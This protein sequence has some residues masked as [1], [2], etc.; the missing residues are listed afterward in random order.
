MFPV[1][2]YPDIPLWPVIK[3]WSL[4]IS[5]R[6]NGVR[7]TSE[8]RVP[9]LSL[10]LDLIRLNPDLFVIIEFTPT[11]LIGFIAGKLLRKRILL[12][13]ETDPA[14]RG[15]SSGAVRLALK[16]LIARRVDLVMTNNEPGRAYVCRALGVRAKRIFV[17][18]YLTSAPP[19]AA[20]ESEVACKT[21]DVVSEQIR[22]LYLNSVTERKG[23]I[24]LIQACKCLTDAEL[25]Q[26]IFDVV[27]DGP[28]LN[29]AKELVSQYGMG[30]FF[31]FHGSAAHD[32]I[33][34]YYRLADIFVS[35][36][37]ADYRSLTAFEALSCGKPLLLSRWDSASS[38]VVRNGSN[39]WII[40]PCSPEELAERLVWFAK[41]RSRIPEFAAESKE[42]AQLFSF[43]RIAKNLEVATHLALGSKLEI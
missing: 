36:T 20:V 1:S 7:Y 3:F 23:L 32:Q 6:I 26:F 22:V 38:E 37:L 29:R 40:D 31:K 28:L 24:E 25:G 33:W 19:D 18:P 4:G 12:L 17:A 14:F 16:R 15:A 8:L 11:A 10:L 42:H 35:P 2:R 41:N 30:S 34:R 21:S 39:G 13:V 9:G 43:E 5:R 27:G